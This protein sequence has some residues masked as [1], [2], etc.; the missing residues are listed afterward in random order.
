[1][2][3]FIRHPSNI[4]IEC[5]VA[6][7]EPQRQARLKN[8]SQG[9]L[10][11][12]SNHSLRRGTRICITIPVREPAFETTGTIAWCR[13]INGHYD[14]GVQFPDASTEFSVRMVEQVCRIHQYQK[15]VLEKE[16]RELSSAEAA[17]EWVAKYA[18]DFPV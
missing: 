8:V 9:G 4:P 2:R 5:R 10:C 13:R 7:R 16:G 18:K 1:M 11:F 14:V 6:E 15:E 17:L 12:Q 3:E